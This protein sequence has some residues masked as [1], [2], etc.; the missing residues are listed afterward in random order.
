MR[1]VG[2]TPARM[3]HSLADC[4][5]HIGFHAVT[6]SRDFA[7]LQGPGA[8]QC[9][10]Q[11]DFLVA[12]RRFLRLD[13]SFPFLVPACPPVEV[14]LPFTGDFGEDVDSSTHVFA[15]FCVVRRSAIQTVSLLALPFTRERAEFGCDS[16]GR[17]A[18]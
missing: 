9:L 3:D 18:W 14:C 15:A 13:Y 17:R 4:L 2:Q 7:F 5:D 10:V 6:K 8:D 11:E 1:S 16:S 12:I